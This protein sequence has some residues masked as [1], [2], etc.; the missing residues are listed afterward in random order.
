MNYLIQVLVLRWGEG[1]RQQLTLARN[2]KFILM[3]NHPFPFEP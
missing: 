1:Q 3:I 2:R